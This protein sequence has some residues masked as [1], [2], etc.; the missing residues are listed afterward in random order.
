MIIPIVGSVDHVMYGAPCEP[1]LQGSLSKS[2]ISS[3]SHKVRQFALMPRSPWLH[4][5]E[6][7]ACM[8]YF[9]TV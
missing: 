3:L 9:G 1:L 6:F 7:L 8:H 2:V 5:R 4:S